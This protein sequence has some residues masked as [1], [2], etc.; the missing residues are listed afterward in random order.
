VHWSV[1]AADG[2][3]IR[4]K[5]EYTN[6]LECH[7]VAMRMWW[8]LMPHPCRTHFARVYRK[9]QREHALI[10]L[11]WVIPALVV[12]VLVGLFYWRR[13]AVP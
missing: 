8:E 3:Q 13:V 6:S 2:S 5:L 9:F 4:P 12:Y 1:R 7:T 11:I 10:H